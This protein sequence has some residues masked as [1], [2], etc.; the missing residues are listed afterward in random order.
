MRTKTAFTLYKKE[1]LDLL[2]DKKTVIVMILVP[3]LLYP[4][5]MLLSLLIMK[6]LATDSVER[7]YTVGI[8]ESE[9]S[10]DIYDILTDEKDDLEYH[11]N[12]VD[13][14]TLDAAKNALMN[15]KI[16]LII[17]SNPLSDASGIYSD[18]ELFGLTFYHMAS[19]TQSNNAYQNAKEVFNAYSSKIRKEA[20]DKVY[21]DSESVL[22]P[23]P[24]KTESISSKEENAGSLIGMILPFILI[25]SILTGA[26]Y[27]AIDATAGERERGTLETI[28]T[29]PVRKSEIMISKF[30]SVSTIAVFSALLNLLSMFGMMLIMVKIVDLQGLGLTDFQY[31]QF[32]PAFISL[33]LCLPIFS[34]FASAVSL[35]ICIFA[36]SFKEANNIT[37]PILIVFMFA[38]M[39]SILPTIELN[40]KTAMIPVTNIALLIKSV[41]SLDY[42]IKLVAVVLFSNL[43]YCI[44]MVILMSVFFSSEEVLFGEGGNGIHVFELRANMKKGS[45]PGYGDVFLLF[46]VLIL[47]MIYSGSFFVLKWGIWGTAF[48]QLLIFGMPVLYSLYIKADMK[49]LYSLRLPKLKNIFGAIIVWAGAFMINQVIVHLL[50]KAFP[51]MIQNSESLNDSILSAGFIPALIVVG[52]MPAIAEEAAF[53]GF[54][55]GTLKHKTKIIIAIVVSAALFG[56][57]HMNLLQFF[58]GLFMGCFMAYMTYKSGSILPSVLFHLLNNS[59]SV[60][61]TYYPVLIE[62]I[63]VLGEE[64]LN[65][66]GIFILLGAGIV[67]VTIG[68]FL[69][70]TGIPKTKREENP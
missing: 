65:V 24:M 10:M 42:D 17:E 60:I 54:L 50:A 3:I 32:V 64:N 36:K 49:K 46:S 62:K 40:F 30:L 2:R 20:F 7:T 34:M 31:S 11:F 66:S 15:K 44:I 39:A 13:Y 57:Y 18:D 6:G 22:N 59:L 16:D 58:T 12:K 26:I 25:I 28:M 43:A 53:R 67:L 27:P 37:S 35:C 52:F 33:L 68:V 56:A 48:V 1:I 4:A 51:S 45:M 63:P 8:V 19:N 47:V 55:F 23:I 41:F 29:L 61:A 38:A 69:F 70:M 21:T 9:V 14:F 5:M